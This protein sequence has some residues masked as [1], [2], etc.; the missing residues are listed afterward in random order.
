MQSNTSDII[1]L[2]S[3][4]DFEKYVLKCN[5]PVIVDFYADW[6]PP[7]KKLIPLI[8]ET[9][10]NEGT[11]RLVKVNVDSFKSLS[12]SYGVSS[13]PHVFLFSEGESVNDFKGYNPDGLNAMIK[14]VAKLNK[15]KAFSGKGYTIESS[16]TT[17]KTSDKDVKILEDGLPAEPTGDDCYNIVIRSPT[18]DSFSRKF[19]GD[20][21]IGVYIYII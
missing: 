1:Q 16:V 21:S 18:G 11:F 20:D 6:C 13:I 17:S 14:E 10:K 12:K 2:S 9:C 7:C 15:P 3:E 5:Y 19:N 8:E 4:S